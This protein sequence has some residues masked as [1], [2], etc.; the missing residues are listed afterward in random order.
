MAFA[1]A[2]E[3]RARVQPAAQR[4]RQL[5]LGGK[6][7]LGAV[8]LPAAY[9]LPGHKQLI[10]QL[11]L[12][13]PRRPAQRGQSAS[14]VLP[15]FCPQYSTGPLPGARNSLLPA[16]LRTKKGP[17]PSA[18]AQCY[19]LNQSRLRPKMRSRYKN[20]LMK[21]RYS[22]NAAKMEAFFAMASL[23]A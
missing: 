19:G 20:R 11:L 18:P 17:E 6:I 10:R 12:A 15:V 1:A 4:R 14:K 8:A 7:R 22:C 16:P 13:Q 2:T 5:L 23:P 21:S 9:R 3:G